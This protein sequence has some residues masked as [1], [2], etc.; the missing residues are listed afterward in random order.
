MAHYVDGYVLTVPKKKLSAYR[1]MAS[2]AG[3]I[4]REYGALEYVECAGDDLEVPKGCL[5]FTRMAKARPGE[6]VI[7]S[8]VVFKSR[9]H[10]DRVNAQVMGDPRL[11]SLCD[12]KNPPFDFKRMAH[13]GFK[14][15]VEL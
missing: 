2:R 3:K 12:P 7:F 1:L 11:A 4:W 8:Y 9:A 5:P 13:G 15:I 10:R 6:T 14:P